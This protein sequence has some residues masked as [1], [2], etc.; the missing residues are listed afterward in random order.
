[1]TKIIVINAIKIW[2]HQQK[3]YILTLTT[4][5]SPIKSMLTKLYQTLILNLKLETYKKILIVK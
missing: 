4:I 1:M 5:F 3:S 2:L